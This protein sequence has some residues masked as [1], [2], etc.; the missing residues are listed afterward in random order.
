M[1]A[2]IASIFLASLVGSLHCAGMCGAFV[3]LAVGQPA[4][5]PAR[6]A[7]LQAAYHLGRLLTYVSLG[8]LAGLLGQSVDLGGSLLGIQRS[9]AIL[10]AA[11]MVL[12][13]LITLA[14]LAGIRLPARHTPAFLTKLALAGHRLAA[15]LRPLPR[16]AAIGLLTTLIPCGWLYSFVILA[17]GTAHPAAAAATM[18]IFWLGTLPML[19]T[20]GTAVQKLH[21]SLSGKLPAIAA[22]L[23]I[24]IGLYTLTLRVRAASAIAAMPHPTSAADIPAPPCCTRPEAP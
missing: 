1:N 18:A 21:T 15:P 14:R 7:A 3:A 17:A 16:A 20:L 8:A 13:G 24:T 2:L 6:K 12:F 11:S 19:V 5:T 23:V 10:A 22:L 4:A 9:A